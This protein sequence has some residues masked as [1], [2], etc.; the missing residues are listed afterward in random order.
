MQRP[1]GESMPA[2]D[3][4]IVNSGRNMAFTPPAR[5]TEDSP[6]CRLWQARWTATRDDEQAV[7]RERLGPRRSNQ[8]EIRLAA[9]V[10]ALPVPVWGPIRSRFTSASWKSLVSSVK[11]PTKTPV[12]EPA[13]RRAGMPASSSASQETSSSQRCIGSRCAASR[14]DMPKNRASKPLT[15]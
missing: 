5:A 11:T 12:G 3:S 2:F 10:M 8:Y 13:S 9:M 4:A 7:S 15:G 1:S 14:G 6:S